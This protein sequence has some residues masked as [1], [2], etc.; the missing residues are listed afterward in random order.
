MVTKEI[1]QEALAKRIGQKAFERLQQSAVAVAGLGGLGSHIA[2][3]LARSG[4]GKLFWWILIRW[5]FPISTV[6]FTTSMILA[7]KTEA[8]AEIIEEINP[9]T[10]VE[11]LQTRV[12]TAN[13]G[14][15]LGITPLFV[16]PLTLLRKRQC[17]S[18]H[19]WSNV[20][21]PLSFPALVWQDTAAA[22]KL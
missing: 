22:M 7:S 20:P 14:N 5:I 19:Y 16:K 17:S 21:I 6:K 4:V 2:V 15:F 18:I 11:T 10:V 1:L 12:S 3:M 9:Y 13:V 8:M